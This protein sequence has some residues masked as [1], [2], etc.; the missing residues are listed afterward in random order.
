MLKLR[1]GKAELRQSW[2]VGCVA[3]GVAS[4]RVPARAGSRGVRRPRA[5]GQIRRLVRFAAMRCL[6][7]TRK[8]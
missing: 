7:T 5:P 3:M 8:I 4:T 2:D 1:M 6:G